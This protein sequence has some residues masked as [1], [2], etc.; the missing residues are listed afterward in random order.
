MRGCAG[1]LALLI[2][3]FGPAPQLFELSQDL[4][5]SPTGARTFPDVVVDFLPAAPQLVDDV[6]DLSHKQNTCVP[7]S[8]NN[9]PESPKLNREHGDRSAV[10]TIDR[11]RSP[12]GTAGA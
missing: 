1:R 7:R 5:R 10:D 12:V 9:L 11:I 8:A 4:V 3:D 6:V 2:R